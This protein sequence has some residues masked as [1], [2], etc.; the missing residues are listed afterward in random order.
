[1][2]GCGKLAFDVE[3]LRPEVVN[4]RKIGY[5]MSEIKQIFAENGIHL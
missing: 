3:R 5:K 1:M 4:K 2:S